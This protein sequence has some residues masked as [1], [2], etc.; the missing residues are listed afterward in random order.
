MTAESDPDVDFLS[1]VRAGHQ[2]DGDGARRPSGV[3]GD[4]ITC[5]CRGECGAAGVARNEQRDGAPV[6][7]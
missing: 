6:T 3:D 7:H 4:C 5:G 2:R 1:P